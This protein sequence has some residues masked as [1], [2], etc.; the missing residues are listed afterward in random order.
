MSDSGSYG[1]ISDEETQAMY[2]EKEY[3]HLK[4][5]DESL[6]YLTLAGYTQEEI[7]ILLG[8]VAEHQTADEEAEEGGSSARKGAAAAAKASK[9]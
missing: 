7:D 8:D 4:T 2:D 6:L 3:L 5:Y 9:K 1:E